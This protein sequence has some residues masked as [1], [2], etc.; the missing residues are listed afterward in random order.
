MGDINKLKDIARQAGKIILS[1]YNT[2]LVV[3]NKEDNSPVTLADT[4]ANDYI[5]EHLATEFPDI[6]IVSEEGAKDRKGQNN[7]FLVDPL[8]G[9]KGFIRKSGEFTVNIGLIESFRAKAGVIYVPV[10]DEMYFSD[11]INSYK[12]DVQIK[13]RPMPQDAVVLVAS[14]SHRNQETNDFIATVK[15]EKIISAASS[16]KFCM[17]AEGLADIYPRFGRTM[18]WDTAAGHAILNN[19]G[20]SVTNPDGSE[21]LY[22][23]N[24]IFENGYF[25]AWGGA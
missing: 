2:T 18:E 8:D 1:H 11:G 14:K 3:E 20:G 10:T 17:V 19:A 16:L 7:F 22:G 13:C 4:E 12:N 15:T 21:F 5:V 6:P 23:K 25:V 9:T 24:N